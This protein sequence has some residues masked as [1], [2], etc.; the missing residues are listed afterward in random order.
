M[1]SEISKN[2][3][4]FVRKSLQGSWGPISL[5]IA[6]A[7][8]WA[9][10]ISLRPYLLKLILNEVAEAN[11]TN[12]YDTV[13]WPALAYLAMTIFIST[14]FRAHGYFVE[15][16]MVP[17]LRQNIADSIFGHLLNQSHS[18]YQNQFSGSLAN[19]IADL[20]GSIPEVI[21]IVIDRFFSHGLALLI[22]IYALWQVSI[23]FAII[24]VSFVF[25]F[26]IVSLLTAKKLGRLAE[27][28]SEL[29]SSISGQIVD[30][31]SNVMSVRLFT[32]KSK[33]REFLRESTG[34]AVIAERKLQ[35]TYFSIFS[36]YGYSLC[37]LLGANLYFLIIGR[38]EGHVSV[39]DFALV[40]SLNVSISDFLWD[41][42]NQFSQFSKHSGKI[43]Q[44]LRTTTTPI[45]IPDSPGALEL[46][47]SLGEIEFDKVGFFYKGTEPLFNDKSI[48]IEAGQKVG[49]VGYSGSGKTTFVNV[50]LRLFNVTKGRILIDGQD[51]ATVSQESLRRAIGMIPQD[52]SLFHRTLIDNIRY[53]RQEATD[54]EVIDA[55]KR[56]HAHEFIEILPEGYMALVGERGVKLSGGQRQ[57]I[58]IARAILKNAPILMLDEATSQLDSITENLIQESLWQL[59][60][61]KTTL[62]VAHRLSTLMH[63]DRIL[64]F[65][66][67]RIVQ[68][69][70]HQQLLS[71]EGMYK[72]LWSAQIGGFLPDEK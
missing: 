4:G 16:K 44:A 36:L 12:L 59:M 30:V 33:E 27:N 38:Q 28:W 42:T 8:I 14:I 11:P 53:G 9:I 60:Q 29:S 50:I 48:R 32:S 47:V 57:R 35:W 64:V 37:A 65:N 63:M 1:P 54:A 56:A 23:T 3:L 24:M 39:G 7:I 66:K 15:Y 17:K 55:A 6:V 31:L 22:A 67:G 13:K 21:Q 18:Y 62:V 49:L 51:I 26:L 58:A 10:D 5:M 19:K 2:A 43:T 46:K 45:G 69:G 70:T 40:L 34:K 25:L 52:P 41:L 71:Q 72:T 68:D 20:T 61:G